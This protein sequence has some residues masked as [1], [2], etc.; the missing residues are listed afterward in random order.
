MWLYYLGRPQTHI[1]YTFSVECYICMSQPVIKF[2]FT[3]GL[4]REHVWGWTFASL[5][6]GLMF[7]KSSFSSL[8]SAH[9]G[10]NLVRLYDVYSEWHTW[11]W[12]QFSVSL[13]QVTSQQMYF[14]Y[15]LPMK[16]L[17]LRDSFQRNAVWCNTNTMW[18]QTGIDPSSLTIQYNTI[19]L[20]VL[21][22]DHWI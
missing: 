8:H 22:K 15:Y 3:L 13:H 17:E 9:A 4:S 19:Q 11:S 10:S 1:L 12:T 2:F 7:Y 18:H 14:R 20:N 21:S 5:K 16:S 6:L